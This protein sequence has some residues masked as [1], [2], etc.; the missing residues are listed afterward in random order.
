MNQIKCKVDETYDGKSI[1]EFLKKEKSFSRRILKS[2]IYDG[3]KVLL[4]DRQANL[5]ERLYEN[6]VLVIEF[7]EEKKGPWMKPEKIALNI[8]YEDD[9]ILVVDKPAHM[10]TI[11]SVHHPSGTLANA[12]LFHYLE[13]GLTNTVHV[14]T[15]LDRGTSGLLLIAKNRYCHSLFANLQQEEGIKRYYQAVISGLLFEKKGI[16][17]KNIG[18]KNDS[19]IERVVRNDGKP[20]ITL[21]ET[22]KQSDTHT[23][24]N[25]ELKTGRTHQIR[26][27]FAALGYPLAGDDL[28]GGTRD[29]INRQALHCHQI[30]FKHPFTNETM[31]FFSPLPDDMNHLVNGN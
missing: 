2:M 4:N 22:I 15:R 8:V 25:V 20:A 6:D 1:R 24:V 26:V 14:V 19:M 28:Y 7:P 11:P 9:F 12:I 5:T 27:H 17:N 21:F 23:L 29:I 18:R 10:T 30:K 31:E 3:G 13:N 16:I